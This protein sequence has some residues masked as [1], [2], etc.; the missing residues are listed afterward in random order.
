MTLELSDDTLKLIA[1]MKKLNLTL[2]ETDPESDSLNLEQAAVLGRLAK[3]A[4]DE[5]QRILLGENETVQKSVIW[6]WRFIKTNVEEHDRYIATDPVWSLI[7]NLARFTGNLAVKCP[8]N[9]T[10]IADEC[11]PQMRYIVHFLTSWYYTDEI[12]D[13]SM[14]RAI[15]RC[16]SNVV[17][18]NEETS[19]VIWTKYM[20]LPEKDNLITRLLQ[21]PD[22]QTSVATLVFILNCLSTNPD[23]SLAMATKGGGRATCV[24]LLEMADRIYEN[25]QENDLFQL[26]FNVFIKLFE[27]ESLA[28]LYQNLQSQD[29]TISPHQ[30]T[31]LKLL[32][33]HIDTKPTAC[34][35]SASV[36]SF[37]TATLSTLLQTTKSWVTVDPNSEASHTLNEGL[38]LVS[39]ATVLV[40]QML[41]NALMAEQTTWEKSTDKQIP[42]RPILNTLRDQVGASIEL[43]I[44]VLR[45]LDQLIPRIQFGEAKP[46][47][48]EANAP[49]ADKASLPVTRF[50]FQKRDLVRLLGILVHDDTSIQ[51]RVREAGGVQLILGLCVID[52]N[53]PFIRE[54]ALFT[55]RNLLHKNTENQQI[56]REMEP[57]GRIDE[58][59]IVTGI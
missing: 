28:P 48:A 25:D 17:T 40:S 7:Y 14:A 1:Q 57:T 21:Y 37:L 42:G 49:S 22:R 51:T 36:S 30:I 38:P 59:G 53:N 8:K 12:P 45:R 18:E 56:V 19:R 54:H 3:C 58:N 29:G 32:D 33:G 26:I 44:D 15:T 16:L 46:V 39:A 13:R 55:L 50:Q 4:V 34:E 6:M 52:E 10:W 20:S 35:E 9:Q 43:I 41:A 2:S 27:A 23:Q 47:V 11:E 5:E 31:L 24:S